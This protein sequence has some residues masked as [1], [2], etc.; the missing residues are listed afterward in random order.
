ML[1][2]FLFAACGTLGYAITYN[3]PK[4]LLLLAAITGGCGWLVFFSMPESPVMGCFL[5]AMAVGVLGEV[6]S[7]LFK[8][9]ATLFIL[10]GILPLVPGARMYKMT[11]SL[12][13]KDF[14]TAASLAIEVLS[15]AG[16]IAE[17]I[18]IIF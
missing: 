5:A 1:E 6:F 7:R 9:A 16:S 14:D 15:F 2:A 3:I 13:E 4:K 18:D 12:L 17:R 10:P 8:D 11:L